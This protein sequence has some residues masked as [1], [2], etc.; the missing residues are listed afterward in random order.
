M[1]LLV[2][3]LV[4]FVREQQGQLFK[5]PINENDITG[6]S[7]LKPAMKL[8]AWEGTGVCD[9]FWLLMNFYWSLFWA[10]RLCAFIYTASLVLC[11]SG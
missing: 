2:L 7:N 10:S 4:L 6:K 8:L 5:S 9:C 11:L 3:V 1:L